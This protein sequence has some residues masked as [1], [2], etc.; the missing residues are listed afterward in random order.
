[1]RKAGRGTLTDEERLEAINLVL[2]RLDELSADHVIVV[3]GKKDRGALEALGIRGDMFQVQSSGGPACAAEYVGEHGGKAVILT[4]WDRRGD[5]LAEQLAL[6]L[7]K[8][9]PDTVLDVRRDLSGLCRIFIKDVES[10]DS[11]VFSLTAKVYDRQRDTL[12]R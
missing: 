7:G 5:M 10:L 8:D 1:M 4:D 12:S 9:S 3:E 6:L 2:E 11:F